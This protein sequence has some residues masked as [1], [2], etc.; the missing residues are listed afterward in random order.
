MT[1]RRW[2]GTCGCA[3]LALAVLACG[4]SERRAE[5]EGATV[6]ARVGG[7]VITQADLDA[8]IASLPKHE[9]PQYQSAMGKRRFLNQLVDRLLL[10]AAAEDRGLADDPEVARRLQEW[11]LSVLSAAYTN[12]LVEE[13]PKPTE[14]DLRRYYDEHHEEFVV[15]AR[16]KASWIRCATRKEAEAVRRRVTAQGE[17]FGT[18]AREVSIDKCS[19]EDGGLLGYFNPGGYVRCV[20]NREEFNRM[21]FE[22]EADDVSDAFEW[23]GTWAIV[24]LHEKSTERQESYSKARERIA[25]RMRPQLSDSLLQAE[26]QRLRGRFEVQVLL[27]PTAAFADKPAEEL[28]QMATEAGAPQDKIDIYRVL[29]EKYPHHERADEAQFMIAFLTSENLEDH[30]TARREYQKLLDNYPDSDMRNDAL[31]MLQNLG[32]TELPVFEDTPASDSGGR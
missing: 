12:A 31:Y 6:L 15:L 32:R 14:E 4:G 28:M 2:I 17:H 10:V 9:Q 5:R 13:L 22:L 25:A 24:K 26:L 30:E 18:V 29:L 23:D 27:D 16:V 11:R 8:T 21:V 7:H 20:G 3:G 1:T 19:K